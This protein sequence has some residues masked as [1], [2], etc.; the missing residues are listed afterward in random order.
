MELFMNYK[1]LDFIIH[2]PYTWDMILNIPKEPD[3]VKSWMR[4]IDANIDKT[5]GINWDNVNV[6]YGNQLPKYLWEHWGNQL[7]PQG[8]TWQIFLRILKHR[9]DKVLLWNKGILTWDDLTQEIINLVE[10]PFGKEMVA[11][12]KKK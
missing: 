2:T 1:M 3:H 9:T 6:W 4:T 8:F 7:K 11:Q 12:Y 10:G 5:P